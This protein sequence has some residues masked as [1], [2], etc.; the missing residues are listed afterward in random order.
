[1]SLTSLIQDA[2]IH[3]YEI[4]LSALGV[5]EKYRFHAENK[6]GN[7]L[8]GGYSFQEL[9]IKVE[10]FEISGRGQIPTPTLTVSNIFGFFSDLISEYDGLIGAKL[11][12]FVTTPEYLNQLNDSYT[13]T[14]PDQWFISNYSENQIA[15]SFLLKS[16]F[17]LEG[18]KV[19]NR[20]I[21]R[22]I[23]QWRY[24]S[25][26]CGYVGTLPSCLN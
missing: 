16:S 24:K 12:R 13:I 18:V 21:L 9:P 8:F 20:I 10:G 4:D 26:E 3:L 19:P 17:D 14:E 23:C 15:V 25:A 7:I 1:M 22:D 5:S 11:T 2:K 6:V